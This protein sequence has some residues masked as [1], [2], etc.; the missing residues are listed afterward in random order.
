MGEHR[1]KS[2]QVWRRQ[3]AR[4]G[5]KGGRDGGSDEGRD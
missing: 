3:G 2:T 4:L 5:E 1:R